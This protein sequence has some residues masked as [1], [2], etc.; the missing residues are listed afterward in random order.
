MVFHVVF[1]LLAGD[2]FEFEAAGVGSVISGP[3]KDRIRF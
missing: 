3:G 1:I 2:G